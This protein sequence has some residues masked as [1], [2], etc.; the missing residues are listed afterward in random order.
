MKKYLSLLIF[1]QVAIGS[2]IF[3]FCNAQPGF[4]KVYSIPNTIPSQAFKV[5]QTS[6]G[7]YLILGLYFYGN[8][9]S[10]MV[11]IKTTS[12]G[13]TIWTKII[14]DINSNFLFNPTCMTELPNGQGYVIGGFFVIVGAN[15][16]DP[17]AVALD[18]NGNMLWAKEYFYPGAAET[19]NS[20]INTLDGNILFG[21][22]VTGTAPG[23]NFLIM[24]TDIN[25]NIIWSRGIQNVYN[26]TG[27]SNLNH[28][29]LIQLPDSSIIVCGHV[30]KYIV[31]DLQYL[32]T[33][34]GK[35]SPAGDFLWGKAYGDSLTI[36]EPYSISYDNGSN[37]LVSGI[38]NVI[39][40]G[41]SPSIGYMMKVDTAG[42]FSWYREYDTYVNNLFA[43]HDAK[44]ISNGE[45]M[46]VK[47]R[48]FNGIQAQL[49]KTDA[50]GIPLWNK[51]YTVPASFALLIWNFIQTTDNGFALCGYLTNATGSVGGSLLV[52]TDS[53]GAYNCNTF[54]SL[55]SSVQFNIQFQNVNANCQVL[56]MSDSSKMF[57]D[58]SGFV[59]NDACSL[60]GVTDVKNTGNTFI[61]YPNPAIDFITIKYN[62]PSV[63]QT[64]LSLFNLYGQPLATPLT[65]RK[66]G[67]G[68]KGALSHNGTAEIKIDMRSFPA[69]IY[70]IKV[71]DGEKEEVR[72]VVKY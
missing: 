22:H 52:K 31:N 9:Y 1:V 53:S 58:S 44:I 39:T 19:F 50:N 37:L 20:C 57:N 35:L 46:A 34:I 29:R 17:F 12:T 62:I 5:L 71:S 14:K 56:A 40:T 6:D 10:N 21:G 55:N 61:V 18:L 45:I 36:T 65:S 24:K 63:Q 11:V 72:K 8:N 33:F 13:D 25:G 30:Q 15:N 64:T 4:Q 47:I 42:N 68:S 3:S 66:S 32:R 49:F 67:T 16:W 27:I 59:L 38:H 51:Y 54:D 43:I 2:C 48:D 70:F 69:G 23:T 28:E 26:H 60:T 7:G 41:I